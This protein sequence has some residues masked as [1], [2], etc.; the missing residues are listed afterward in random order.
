MRS[1]EPLSNSLSF[2]FLSFISYPRAHR[3]K[4]FLLTK[5]PCTMLDLNKHC[6]CIQ[7][8]FESF[9]RDKLPRNGNTFGFCDVSWKFWF[10]CV[11][12]GEGQL[13]ILLV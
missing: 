13:K 11:F 9:I 2:F 5:D 7:R 6:V 1:D 3:V 12:I 4:R 8:V 10:L